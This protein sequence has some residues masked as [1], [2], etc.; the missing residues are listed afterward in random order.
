MDELRVRLNQSL[1]Q[2]MMSLRKRSGGDSRFDENI[3]GIRNEMKSIEKVLQGFTGVLRNLD[4]GLGKMSLI[5]EQVEKF[6]TEGIE[7]SMVENKNYLEDILFEYGR[8][9]KSSEATDNS[10]VETMKSM[11]DTYTS[12]NL[13]FMRSTMDVYYR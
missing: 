13:S 9:S 8:L 4:V 7:E 12:N 11:F 10:V 6:D 5:I 2:T 3:S 1:E